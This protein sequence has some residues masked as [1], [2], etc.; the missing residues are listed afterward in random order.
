MCTIIVGDKQRPLKVSSP[1][2]A[3][4]FGFISV[5][6]FFWQPVKIVIHVYAVTGPNFSY[7][8]WWL[9][10]AAQIRQ[11]FIPL[12]TVEFQLIQQFWLQLDIIS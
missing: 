3:S 6:L 5:T 7:M 4:K 1:R 10:E 2:S 12:C 8:V 11:T 9:R